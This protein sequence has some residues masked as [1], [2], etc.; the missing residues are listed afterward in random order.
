MSG[1]QYTVKDI[2]CRINHIYEKPDT[3]KCKIKKH[4]TIEIIRLR[5]P[6]T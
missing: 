4:R 5:M 1:I 2:N 3:S 6:N